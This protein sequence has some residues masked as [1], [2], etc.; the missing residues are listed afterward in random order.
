ML[1]ISGVYSFYGLMWIYYI[2]I[3][4]SRY[5]IF[6]QFGTIVKKFHVNIP[7]QIFVWMYSFS[8]LGWISRNTISVSFGMFNFIR[9]CQIV[10]FCISR[11]LFNIIATLGLVSLSYLPLLLDVK[12][13]L[14]VL[15]WIFWI[16]NGIEHFLCWF[17]MLYLLY[18][19]IC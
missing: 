17:A 12:W 18:W 3:I 6:L 15:I 10:P 9:N 13:H 5:L 4:F 8:C 19:S 1:H 16:I 14:L 7:V 2:Y 11:I